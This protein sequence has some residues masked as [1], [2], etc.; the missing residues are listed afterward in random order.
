MA[1]GACSMRKIDRSARRAKLDV[2]RANRVKTTY[3]LAAPKRTLWLTVCMAATCRVAFN[4]KLRLTVQDLSPTM[5]Y[6]PH[7]KGTY[8]LPYAPEARGAGDYHALSS[9]RAYAPLLIKQPR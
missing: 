6:S 3:L 9:R 1:A 2:V 8:D 5:T 4:R 7:T